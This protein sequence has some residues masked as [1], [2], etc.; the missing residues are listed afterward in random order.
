MHWVNKDKIFVKYLDLVWVCD[1]PQGDKHN[2]ED[3]TVGDE[4]CGYC[5]SCKAFISALTGIVTER[6]AKDKDNEEISKI[7]QVLQ[8]RF[9]VDFLEEI[10]NRS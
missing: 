1:Y 10:K 8:R 9:R 4:H 2:R 5:S 7:I 6:Y 3:N